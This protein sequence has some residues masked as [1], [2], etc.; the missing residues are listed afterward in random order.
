MILPLSFHF[1]FSNNISM[2]QSSVM[3]TSKHRRRRFFYDSKWFFRQ[4]SK[5]NYS[6]IRFF[7][8]LKQ[9]FL[10]FPSHT[11]SEPWRVFVFSLRPA[12]FPTDQWSLAGSIL[13]QR[14][15]WW[16]SIEATRDLHL[17]PGDPCQFCGVSS[18]H[19]SLENE[20]SVRIYDS[21]IN[22]TRPLV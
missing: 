20:L 3:A 19:P 16:P 17:F 18:S 2:L 1:L 7:V 8:S 22:H 13:G 10:I 14:Q 15:R 4:M 6:T 5:T 12:G 9:H 11:G 21:V